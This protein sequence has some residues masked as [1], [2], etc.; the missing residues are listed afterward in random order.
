MPA[1]PS[2]RTLVATAVALGL[3]A[4]PPAANGH[5]VVVDTEPQRGEH[6][7]GAP[8]EVLLT[9]N[10]PVKARAGDLRVYDTSSGRVDTGK[11]DQPTATRARVELQ[12]G[13]ERDVYTTTYRVVSADG[14]PVSGGFT[15]GYGREVSAEHGGPTVAELL[16]EEQSDAVDIA[17]GFA[18]GFHYLA[19]LLAIGTAAFVAFVAPRGAEA[20][21]RLRRILVAAAL[22]GGVCSVAGVGLQ[23]A[24]AAGAPID[25]AFSSDTIEVSI[26]NRAGLAW[27]AR[28]LAWAAILAVV[29]LAARWPRPL[30]PRALWLVA[31]ATVGIVAS[32]PLAGHARTQDPSAVLIPADFVHVAAAGTW[33]GGLL[34]LLLVYWPRRGNGHDTAPGWTATQ[35]FSRLAL[36]A[37]VGLV[38]AGTLQTLFYLSSPG[39]L[40]S[41]DYGLVLT[42]KIALLV[43]ILAIAA[44]NRRA[45]GREAS[46]GGAARLRRAMRVEVAL[47][48]A[49]IAAAALLVRTAPPE[50]AEAGPPTPAVDLGPMRL[51]MSIEPGETGTNAAHLYFFDRRSGAQVDRIDELRMDLDPPGDARPSTVDV[52]RKSFA[53]YQLDRLPLPEAGDWK[54]RVLAR[55]GTARYE[56]ETEIDVE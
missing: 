36:P 39:D 51:E 20:G 49:V 38:A 32:L 34:L 5:A 42:A 25:R 11:V 14:H 13:L 3:L 30:W 28:G 26:D 16:D 35:R 37:M 7:D 56:A 46:A 31:A 43:A 52:P 27:V 2:Y 4:A 47:A 17:Y 45:V 8:A 33:L 9:F 41:E 6:L 23:G 15:F 19:L 44:G 22:V 53:H 21:G 48:L 55:V 1:L 40:L 10:E 18:R 24:L 54:L 50:A 12:R 29:L